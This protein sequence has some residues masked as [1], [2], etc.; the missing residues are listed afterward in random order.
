MATHL[1]KEGIVRVGGTPTT[2]AEVRE[3][4][5]DTTS[6]TA[7]TSSINSV[8]GNGGWRTHAATLLAWEG[9]ISCFWDETDTNGQQTIDAGGTVALKLYPEGTTT[10]ATFFSGNAIVTAVNR[11]AAIDGVVE[12]SFSFKGT[13]ALSEGTAP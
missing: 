1:G 7:E 11:K 9:S 12:V 4:Q 6:D 13:G 5:L 2:V 8:Q 10:G 3:W